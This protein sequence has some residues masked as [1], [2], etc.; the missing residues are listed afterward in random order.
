MILML[1]SYSLVP[2]IYP[3]PEHHPCQVIAKM[4]GSINVGLPKWMTYPWKIY[5]IKIPLTWFKMDDLG[6]LPC[7]RKPPNL[8]WL[9]CWWLVN[10]CWYPKWPTEAPDATGLYAEVSLKATRHQPG[11]PGTTGDRCGEILVAEVAEV[12]MDPGKSIFNWSTKN[13]SY[14]FFVAFLEWFWPF[15]VRQKMAEARLAVWFQ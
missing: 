7:F 13:R 6:L 2:L 9:H 8:T 4:D 3:I 11:W 15:W 1:L 5:I 10:I 14:D 12:A